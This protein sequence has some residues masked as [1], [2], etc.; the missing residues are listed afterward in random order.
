[1]TTAQIFP[2]IINPSV[3]YKSY[4]KWLGMLLPSCEPVVL[5]E[6]RELPRWEFCD[7]ELLL[8]LQLLGPVGCR[9]LLGPDLQGSNGRFLAWNPVRLFLSWDHNI[10][11]H[12]L[13]YRRKRGQNVNIFS[14][15][16][17][18]PI[19]VKRG[20]RNYQDG[21]KMFLG[22]EYVRCKLPISGTAEKCRLSSAKFS[23]L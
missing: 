4:L 20:G 16:N 10:Q 5:R 2:T 11:N 3:V 13:V 22:T 14:G 23:D 19:W 12:R 8:V 21:S 15:H 6:S 17:K 18:A 1:M 7:V 9:C